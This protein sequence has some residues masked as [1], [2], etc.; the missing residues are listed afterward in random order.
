MDAVVAGDVPAGG[1]ARAGGFDEALGASSGRYFSSGYRRTQYVFAPFD[2]AGD[3]TAITG[4]VDVGYPADWSLKAG[5]PRSAHLSTIDALVA[6]AA[7]AQ[8]ALAVLC[9][10]NPEEISGAWFADLSIRAGARALTDLEAVPIACRLVERGAESQ[11]G[12][13][14]LHLTVGTFTVTARVHHPWTNQRPRT[15]RSGSFEPSSLGPSPYLS[16][17]RTMEHDSTIT[18]I[19]VNGPT[20]D[21]VHRVIHDP[22]DDRPVGI[23]SAYGPQPTLIDCLVLA[24]QMLQVLVLATAG[25]SREGSGNLWM[26]RIT[27]TSTSPS[28][29]SATRA[30]L[31]ITGQ[32]VIPRDHVVMH[33]V[34]ARCEDLC[35]VTMAAQ[36]AYTTEAE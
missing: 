23:E 28:R 12:V 33:G 13:A 9:G 7:A 2:I 17:F 32:R 26:R 15:R 29:P 1:S 20:M 11:W 16:L 24:G 30:R 4:S 27:F 14:A 21:C 10:L 22:R 6:S 25:S 31:T 5:E 19:D 36:L 34:D 35:G 8:E 3:A 18:C